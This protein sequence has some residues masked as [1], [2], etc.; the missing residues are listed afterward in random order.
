MKGRKRRSE[1]EGAALVF[2]LET[3]L[4]TSAGGQWRAG[5][6]SVRGGLGQDQAA[7]PSGSPQGEGPD[8]TPYCRP[9]VCPRKGQGSRW[10]GRGTWAAERGTGG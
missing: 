5:R 6:Q 2:E 1:K 10:R 8:L 4:G 7:A 9:P 3:G